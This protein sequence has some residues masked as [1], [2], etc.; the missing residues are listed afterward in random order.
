MRNQMTRQLTSGH[1]APTAVLARERQVSAMNDLKR[2]TK[3]YHTY[4]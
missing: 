4:T 1:K 3:I 2:N